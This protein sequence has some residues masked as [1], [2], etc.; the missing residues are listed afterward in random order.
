MKKG[1]PILTLLAVIMTLLG[2]GCG[3]NTPKNSV[4]IPNY[5]SVNVYT[6]NG[7]V[8]RDNIEISNLYK[9]I[10][11]SIIREMQN[12][13]FFS[14]SWGQTYGD[15]V[16]DGLKVRY[17]CVETTYPD[18]YIRCPVKCLNEYGEWIEK[19][20]ITYGNRA[21]IIFSP[22]TDKSKKADTVLITRKLL[23]DKL[24]WND[25]SWRNNDYILSHLRLDDVRNDSI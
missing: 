8:C 4:E 23:V 16:I 11:D 21:G 2:I 7:V 13:H 6:S 5:D 12:V 3:K 25:N 15:T 9:Q 20:T 10:K 18:D 17:N 1:S 19:E 22:A 24:G 14:S